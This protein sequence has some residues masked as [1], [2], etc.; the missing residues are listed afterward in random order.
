MDDPELKCI[1]LYV[2]DVELPRDEKKAKEL[3]LGR[4]L[5]EVVDGILYH[6]EVD[7]SLHLIPS[8]CDW[9]SLFQEVHS[10]TFGAHMKDMKIHGELSKH[11]WW[12]RMRSDIW[13]WCQSCLLCARRQPGRV[14]QPSLIPIPVSGP[15]HRVGVDVIQFTKSHSGN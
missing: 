7:K 9:E 13:K 10:G 1:M 2:E 11:Y 5:Y 4:S 3:V 8:T 6:V 14:V 12:P 15:F